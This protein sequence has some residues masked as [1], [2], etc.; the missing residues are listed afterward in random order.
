MTGAPQIPHWT[1]LPN[2]LDFGQVEVGKTVV[3]G[4]VITNVSGTL[5]FAVSAA[6][7][8]DAQFTL[9][10]FAATY[11]KH[12]GDPDP[13]FESDMLLVVRFTPTIAGIITASVIIDL[14]YW[15]GSAYVTVTHY[16]NVQAEGTIVGTKLL[17]ITPTSLYFPDTIVGAKS[18]Y[19]TV[20]ITNTSISS[21]A[22]LV[23]ITSFSVAAGFEGDPTNPTSAYLYPG[24]FVELRVR[25]APAAGGAYSIAHGI[26][27]NDD[28][29]GNPHYV[30]LVG[31]CYVS[32]P[33]AV[34]SGA[35]TT[36]LAAF[37]SSLTTVALKSFDPTN[38][39][40][41]VDRLAQRVTNFGF[42][43][44]PKLLHD[45]FVKIEDIGVGHL[46]VS[47]L[48]IG[49]EAHSVMETGRVYANEATIQRVAQTLLEGEI[50]DIVFNQ[51][52]GNGGVSIVEYIPRWEEDANALGTLSLPLGA[53]TSVGLLGGG[54]A[55]PSL[56]FFATAANVA[57]AKQFVPESLNC[58]ELGEFQHQTNMQ[59]AGTDKTFVNI[60]AKYEDL[61][62]SLWSQQILTPLD[63][64]AD[65]QYLG[66]NPPDGLIHQAHFK[67][68][69]NGEFVNLA[70]SKNANSGPISFVEF[71]V[72]IEDANEVLGTAGNSTTLTSATPLTPLETVCMAFFSGGAK[73]FDISTLNSEEASLAS[74]LTNI[75][76]PGQEKAVMGIWFKNEDLGV[77][78]IKTS[79]ISKR[80]PLAMAKSEV[81]GTV[82]ADG[83]AKQ[84]YTDHIVKDELIDLHIAR[85][86]NGGPLSLTELLIIMDPAA[87]PVE[88]T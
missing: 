44:I 59:A 17:T 68:T 47:A 20:R 83:I 13:A 70:A 39:D 56:A 55:A 21:I 53:L 24:Q 87:R 41:E 72:R 16:L 1:A 75:Q 36:V 52:S 79:A 19:Q 42:P 57:S 6:S 45:I 7:T 23:S 46:G 65:S 34:N 67:F 8:D 27:I 18:T 62:I 4:I 66:S 82:G 63:I 71:I 30:L 86:A 29:T 28:A 88:R 58:E 22:I 48:I 33:S 43:G 9:V 69:T 51:V 32:D 76:M 61:G 64:D 31:Y 40:S 60:F 12:Q 38:L 25:F 26:T 85:D 81:I 54:D 35:D 14:Y 37:C 11:L 74:H 50:F 3:G 15:N 78:T 73:Q 2:P 77:V 84:G 10:G 5:G 49:Q 80:D